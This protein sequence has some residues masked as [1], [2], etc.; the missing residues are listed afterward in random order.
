MNMTKK[1]VTIDELA[2]MVQS[3][4]AGVDEKFGD[5]RQEMNER[6]N[7]VGEKFKV[8]DLRL[9]GL[10]Q[11]VIGLGKRMDIFADH[12]RWLVKVEKILKVAV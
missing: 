9:D 6:F 7:E 12:D 10:D 5:L 1:N 3:D 4:F 2:T 11:R 8:A